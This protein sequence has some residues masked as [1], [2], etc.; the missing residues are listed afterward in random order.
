MYY[1]SVCTYLVTLETCVI[2]VELLIKVVL[3]AK[4]VFRLV[5][6]QLSS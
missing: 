4:I 6:G 2:L 5:V 3:L 1:I